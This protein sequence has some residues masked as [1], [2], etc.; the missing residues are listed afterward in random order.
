MEG[1]AA[2]P[3]TDA[4][5]KAAI[6]PAIRCGKVLGV[7]FERNTSGRLSKCLLFYHTGVVAVA[8]LSTAIYCFAYQVDEHFGPSLLLKITL[9]ISKALLALIVTSGTLFSWK[10]P[11]LFRR[12]EEYAER[13]DRRPDR[14]TLRKIM[15]AFLAITVLVVVLILTVFVYDF[16]YDDDTYIVRLIMAPFL[17]HCG[18]I[19]FYPLYWALMVVG[20][21][22][23][24][25]CGFVQ[26]NLLVLMLIVCMQE[27]DHLNKRVKQDIMRQDS[28][29]THVTEE[30]GCLPV[31]AWRQQHLE[32]CKITANVDEIYNTLV[33]LL[34]ALDILICSLLA[35]SVF[36]MDMSGYERLKALLVFGSML[37]LSFIILLSTSVAGMLLK[38]KVT[39][40]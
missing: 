22:Q 6:S 19:R 5:L 15:L 21:I 9:H 32:I 39:L 26:L 12:W 25:C 14:R 29:D 20:T 35:Y 10:S 40:P 8:W 30:R 31:E 1:K 37:G 36:M 34:Y 28:A 7:L 11:G 27:Y 13:Y 38:E 2:V 24:I 3:R 16:L 18:P 4:S 33:L 23:V 17:P